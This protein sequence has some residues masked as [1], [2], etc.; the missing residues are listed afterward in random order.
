MLHGLK[1]GG[2]ILGFTL[3]MF[4]ILY[5][6][7]KDSRPSGRVVLWLF[8]GA[9]ALITFV[10]FMSASGVMHLGQQAEDI[11][12]AL[13]VP[14]YERFKIKPYSVCNVHFADDPNA[15]KKGYIFYLSK[16]LEAHKKKFKLS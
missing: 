16:A 14:K 2:L 3:L 7:D 10:I 15:L 8:F 1:L 4:G 11:F 9:L 13:G 5:L 12:R 6:V